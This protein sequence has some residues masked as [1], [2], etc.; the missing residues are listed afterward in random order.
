MGRSVIGAAIL[1]ALLAVGIW[2]Q[3]RMEAVH[4]PIAADMAQAAQLSAAGDWDGAARLVT[5]ARMQWEEHRTFS[6]ALAD[7]QPLEDIEGLM[8]QLDAYGSQE[9]SAFSATCAEIARRVMA[10]AEAHTLTLSTLF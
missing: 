10:V 6:A 8:A 7:H 1:A 9:D 2:T 4:S 5:R 3:N